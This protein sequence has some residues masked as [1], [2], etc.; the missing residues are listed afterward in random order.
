A[1]ID[2]RALAIALSVILLAATIG[3]LFF[4]AHPAKIFTGD[5]GALFIG[6]MIAVISVSGLFKSLTLFS[7]VIPVVILG[8]PI[9]DTFFAIVRRTLKKQKLSTPDNSHL[10]HYLLALGFGHRT[11]VY[12]I[13]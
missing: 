12:I 11:T 13:Y 9:L 7:L 8:V 3:F 10:H 6:Y 5:T 2:G 1:V 4:N